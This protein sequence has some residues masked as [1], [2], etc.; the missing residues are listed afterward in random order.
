[1]EKNYIFQIKNHFCNVTINPEKDKKFNKMF[2]LIIISIL[3]LTAGQPV[4]AIE[5]AEMINPAPGSTLE[6]TEVTFTWNDTGARLYCIYI[7]DIENPSDREDWYNLYGAYQDK[8]TTSVAISGLP[9]DGRTLYVRLRTVIDDEWVYNEYVYTAYF[10]PVTTGTDEFSNAPLL[11]G[12]SGQATASNVNATKEPGEPDH[13]GNTGGKS[14]WWAWTAPQDS[15]YSVVVFDTHGSSFDTLLAVYTGPE[16]S[17]L[18]KKAGNDDD[19]SDNGNSRLA[20]QVQ[21]GERYY[22]VVDGYDGSS[23]DIVL[24]WKMVKPPANDN[25]DNAELITGLSG[26]VTG[27]NADATMDLNEPS[28]RWFRCDV[29][30]SVWWR[31]TAPESGYFS[32]DTHGSDFDTF[33]AITTGSRV[34]DLS[35]D[36]Y[37]NDDGSDKGNSGFIIRTESGLSYNIPVYGCDGESGDIILN[38]KKIPPPE[39][40]NFADASSLEGVSGQITALNLGATKES[41]EPDHAGVKGG[42]S[43]WWTWIVPQTGYFSFDTNGTSFDTVIAVYTGSD[44]GA[45]KKTASDDDNGTDT[46]SNAVFSAQSD[47]RYYIAVDGYNGVFGDIVISWRPAAP[48]LNDNFM[49]A[50]ELTGISGQATGSNVDAT[51]E[52]YDPP[53]SRIF[54]DETDN[55]VWWKWTAPQTGDFSFDTLESSFFT[56]IVITE[57]GEIDNLTYTAYD[58]DTLSFR[59][60]ENVTYNIVIYTCVGKPGNILLKWGI[61]PPP[62]N[63]NYANAFVLAE[64]SGQTSGSNVGATKELNEPDH[65]GI[66][67][68]SSIWWTW[69]ALES[70]TVMLNTNGSNFDTLLAVYSVSE[71]GDMEETAS[72]DNDGSDDNTSSLTFQTDAGVKYYIAVDGYKEKTPGNIVLNWRFISPDGEIYKFERMW[73]TLLQPWYFIGLHD[74]VADNSDYIYVADTW[75]N[76]IQKFTNGGQFVT[77]WGKEGHGD[78][79]FKNPRGIAADSSSFVY[80]TDTSNNCVQKFTSDGRFVKKWGEEGD[81]EGEFSCPHGIVA[82]NDFI[83]VADSCN[84]RIQKFTFDGSYVSAWGQYGRLEGEF[85]YP[86]GITIDN[87]GFIYISEVGNGRVQKFTPEGE[88]VDEWGSDGAGDGEFNQPYGIAIDIEG[89]V[90]VADRSNNRIQ[91][92]TSGG[93]FVTKWGSGDNNIRALYEPYGITFDSNGFIYVTDMDEIHKFTPGGKFIARWGSSGSGDEEFRS[94]VGIAIDSY[95]YVYVADMDN[96]RIQKFAPDGQFEK[97]WGNKGHGNGEFDRLNDVAVDIHGFVYSLDI[98]RST[99]QKFTSDGEFVAK[100]ETS[101]DEDDWPIG[102]AVN[103][104]GFIYTIDNYY[105]NIRKF[106]PDGE[107]I[108]TWGMCGRDQ[109]DMISPSDIAV[110]RSGYIYVADSGNDRIQ[111]YTRD[112]EYVATLG[113][114]GSG[115]GQFEGPDGIAIDDDNYIYVS[116]TFNNRIQKFTPDGQFITTIGEFG[117]AP[118][119]LNKPSCLSVS[120]TDRIYVSDTDNHRIQVF[121]KTDT[122]ILSK[123]II[124]AG[125]G[126]YP[127]NN[128]WPST[129]MSANFAYRSM[130][131]QGFTKETIYYLSSDRD[132]DLDGNGKTDD[133]DDDPTNTNLE[134]AITDWAAQDADRL[135]VYLVDHGSIDENGGYFR[136]N[137]ED[138]RLYASSL[139]KLLNELQEKRNCKVIVIYDACNSGSF[140]PALKPENLSLEDDEFRIVITS[141]EPD[142]FAHFIIQGSVSF[143]NYFWIHIFKGNDVRNAFEQARG[144]MIAP[145]EY[146]HAL[147]DSNGNGLSNETDDYQLAEGVYIGNG[148]I[149]RGDAPEINEVSSLPAEKLDNTST[150]ELIASGVHDNDG[151]SR[152]WAV[153]W[154]PGYNQVTT[155]TAVNELPHVELKPVENYEYRAA[156]DKFNLEGN[157]QV[158]FYAEDGIGDISTPKRI[159]LE[160]NN[161][162]RRKAIILAGKCNSDIMWNAVKKNAG[163]A[164]DALKFQ[165]YPDDDIKFMS[166]EA[167][168]TGVDYAPS[169]SFFKDDILIWAKENTQDLVIYLTGSDSD[170]EFQLNETETLDPAKLK[171][172]LD[173]LQ[174]AW[175][176]QDETVH[177]LAVIYDACR[178]GD[179]IES[180]K[181]EDHKRILIASTKDDGASNYFSD[182]DVSFSQY[183]WS[184]I[185]NGSD[186]EASFEYARKA[187]MALK[188]EPQAKQIPVL[189][190]L[191]NLSQDYIL[192]FGIILA[193]NDPLIG[194]VSPEQTLNGQCSAAIWAKDAMINGNTD[195]FK[196]QA[197]IT[198]PGL[199]KSHVCFIEEPPKDYLILEY[200]KDTER[201][202][203]HYSGFCQ[204][205]EYRISFYAVDRENYPN[206]KGN[207]SIPVST[208][209]IQKSGRKK[210]DFNYDNEITLDD[211]IIV[212]NLLTGNTL[213]D[214]VSPYDLMPC[215][216]VNGDNRIGAAEIA[217]ILQRISNL[218]Q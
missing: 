188:S 150:A 104:D 40:D 218:K 13:S 117:S 100:W 157:Y 60:M 214:F 167:F 147:L 84:N 23:G 179:F 7:R 87:R 42:S 154:S 209:V 152:V 21:A 113:S 10:K 125:G 211:A 215:V 67:G 1:M 121:K 3:F 169:F 114:Q 12:L 38:W 65:A 181:S 22:I 168:S 29:D 186:V 210:G 82:D 159:W 172:W 124:V 39:N 4:M 25:F 103:S 197:I 72:N 92:F 44:I 129:Q 145:S 160:V 110:D 95:S 105:C 109:E 177:K 36:N 97:K 76:R 136:M 207:V 158:L 26:Q 200:N 56:Y 191:Y 185:M 30:H 203:K 62:E 205:G 33:L 193:A 17:N 35:Y 61:I 111:K 45:L 156:Y 106:T 128:L 201:Y 141:T 88:F 192:G 183:F 90:H 118:S 216:D 133:V 194:N 70:G 112:G 108:K 148:T 139:L 79:E 196:I 143:S 48:P 212:L 41:D 137:M 199:D 140:V 132:L 176:E 131:Y 5:K 116:D 202:E 153:I 74:I 101:D 163:L 9:D 120:G 142:E 94:P 187:V 85:D 43:V 80:V 175:K 217:Y 134:Y 151:I 68:W 71:T 37:N 19:G 52:P 14:V 122:S 55:S 81:E 83:Y 138:E 78:G 58:H 135:V 204:D 190:D 54:C 184:R 182:G 119:M 208:S 47:V 115:V 34:D 170:G 66:I 144:A 63:D 53:G 130:I 213:S 178:S 102:I 107:Y 11:S 127:G 69:T 86:A 96:Y 31:W 161:P 123:A 51:M 50:E 180:L 2:I 99:I 18:T 57:G 198:P 189:N 27:S 146:Q 93:E 171:G 165:G 91:K 162:V 64:S 126:P 46:N 16:V 155:P 173:E 89:F 77:K 195:E 6:S 20:C 73:P 174:T 15:D 164:Y 24:N 59:A 28:Y 166:P 49:N 8:G 75:N 32:F 206:E 149:I 98:Y